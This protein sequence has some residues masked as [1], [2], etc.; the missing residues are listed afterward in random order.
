MSNFFPSKPQLSFD[1]KGATANRRA[2]AAAAFYTPSLSAGT[3][4]TLRDWEWMDIGMT[5][6]LDERHKARI[7]STVCADCGFLQRERLLDYSLLLGVYRPPK[8]LLSQPAAKLAELQRLADAC[9]GCGFVSSD[10]QKV[11]FF[12]LIDALEKFTIRWRIQ[13]VVLRILYG[14]TSWGWGGISADGISAMPPTLYADRFKSFVAYEVLQL[15]PVL[16]GTSKQFLD[17]NWRAGEWCFHAWA[18]FRRVCG[19]PTLR[20][21]RQGGQMRW[22][23]LWERRRRGLVKQRIEAEHEDTVARMKELD[24]QVVL[25]AT[26]YISCRS[27]LNNHFH[28]FTHPPPLLAGSIA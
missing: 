11:Y 6:D 24:E 5:T 4:S 23:R 10:R 7:W 20:R 14:V 17:D 22:Q 26:V 25:L 16:M 19:L 21:P 1:L 28:F 27:L 9:R 8:H 13:R 15:N 2:L 3:V 18:M 12:G